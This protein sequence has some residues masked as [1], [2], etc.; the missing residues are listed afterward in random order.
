[1]RD[2]LTHLSLLALL[3]VHVSFEEAFADGEL[4]SVR[5]TPHAFGKVF[6]ESMKMK[7]ALAQHTSD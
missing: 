3:Q 7:K 1:M 4:S 2:A 6:A 5:K